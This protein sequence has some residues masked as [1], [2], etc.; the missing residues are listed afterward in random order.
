[1]THQ[2]DFVL[3]ILGNKKNGVYLEVGAGDYKDMS[4]SYLLEKE[5]GWSGIGIE[6]DSALCKDHAINRSNLC[7]NKDALTINYHEYLPSI[8]INKRIDY[9][10][11]DIDDDP[12]Y[13]NLLGLI[14]VPL[15]EYRFN[16][17][18]F[19]HDLV[20]SYKFKD[21]RD[22]QREILDSLGYVLVVPGIAEDWW[23]DGR[24]M[25]YEKY[26]WAF[27]AYQKAMAF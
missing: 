6:I 7:I 19:E 21:M 14:N 4:N 12:K 17:I 5:Y 23:V 2:S 24:V 27:E 15:N 13:A 26:G 18:T 9:L 8:A 16:V 20:R 22:A 3:S 1:M 10:Q 11:I 25:G